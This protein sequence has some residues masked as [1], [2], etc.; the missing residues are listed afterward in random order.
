MDYEHQAEIW[1]IK[2]HFYKNKISLKNSA[3]SV[4]KWKKCHNYMKN[5][6]RVFIHHYL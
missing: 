5:K 4:V 3:C 1:P 2:P 6:C